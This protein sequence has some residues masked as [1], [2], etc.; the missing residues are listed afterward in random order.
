MAHNAAEVRFL[1]EIANLVTELM[2]EAEKQTGKQEIELSQEI[3]EELYDVW[4]DWQ[5]FKN[6]GSKVQ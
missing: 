2:E 1:E 4:E 5:I 6:Q 3:L